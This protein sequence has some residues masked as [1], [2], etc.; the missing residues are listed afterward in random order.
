MTVSR[1]LRNSAI[2]NSETRARIFDLDG[3]GPY[4]LEEF[5]QSFYAA[6]RVNF[7]AHV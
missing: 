3:N 7:V 4:A 5:E 2:V 6:E 1:A